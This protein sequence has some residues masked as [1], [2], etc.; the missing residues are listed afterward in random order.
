MN[1]YDWLKKHFPDFVRNLGV[2]EDLS[3]LIRAHGDKCYSYRDF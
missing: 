1:H 2:A 3:Y